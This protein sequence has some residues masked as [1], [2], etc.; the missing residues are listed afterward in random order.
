MKK[1]FL[2]L[3]LLTTMFHQLLAS[4]N[5]SGVN[6]SNAIPHSIG[7]NNTYSYLIGQSQLYIEFNASG[8]EAF[9]Q[10]VDNN[11]YNQPIDILQEITVYRKFNCSSLTLVAQVIQSSNAVANHLSITNLTVGAD[12]LIELKRDPQSSLPIKSF[13]MISKAI[14]V[15]NCPLAGALPCNESVQN[16]NFEFADTISPIINFAFEQGQICNWRAESGTPDYT[17]YNIPIFPDVELAGMWNSRTAIDYSS[18]SLSNLLETPTANN[19]IVQVSLRVT[20]GFN[21]TYVNLGPPDELT[22]YLTNTVD[23][24]NIPGPVQLK[25]DN[26]YSIIP[27]SLE[28]GTINVSQT[29]FQTYST[30]TFFEQVDDIYDRIFLVSDN[31]GPDTTYIEFDDVSLRYLEADAGPDQIFDQICGD[32]TTTIGPVDCFVDGATYNWSP[33]IGLSD[34]T[35]RNPI[36]N[37]A[38]INGT[39]TYTLTVTYPGNFTST[40]EVDV[41][42]QNSQNVISIPDGEDITY[43][44]TNYAYNNFTFSNSHTTS[45]TNSHIVNRT[46][47]IQGEFIIDDEFAFVDCEFYMGENAKIIVDNVRA[48]FV[49]DYDAVPHVDEFIKTCD[50]NKFWDG[51]YVQGNASGDLEIGQEMT[52]SNSKNGVVVEDGAATSLG[53]ITFN[54][55]HRCLQ[56]KAT[57]S[58]NEVRILESSFRC[59][60]PLK[61]ET[62]NDYYPQYCIEVN[63][64]HSTTDNIILK[65]AVDQ[66]AKIE[67]TAGGIYCK[68]SST[69][70][71][72]NFV[73]SH[74]QNQYTLIFPAPPVVIP[75]STTAIT[76]VTDAN[77]S[78]DYRV[79]DNT[80]SSCQKGIVSSGDQLLEVKDESFHSSSITGATFLN[81]SDNDG[82]IKVLDN[83]IEG[84]QNGIYLSNVSDVEIDGNTID[85]EVQGSSTSYNS[86]NNNQSLGIY[87]NNFYHAT[88]SPV[89][90]NWEPSIDIR[91]NTIKHASTGISCYF[92]K[93]DIIN[94]TILDMNDNL[95]QP[96]CLPGNPCPATPAYGIKATGTRHGY[97]IRENK[98]ENDLS[99][100]STDPVNLDVIGITMEYTSFDPLS[101][102]TGQEI[103]CNRTVNVG[104]GLRFVGD[105]MSS[106][107]IN[108]NV[109]E[110][111]YWGFVLANNGFIGDVGESGQFSA[112]NRW[113]GSYSNP[114][115]HTF[116]DE[117]NGSST[118]FYVDN[119]TT[120]FPL[121]NI[122]DA[123]PGF[124]SMASNV[125][126]WPG[127]PHIAPLNCSIRRKKSGVAKQSAYK[128]KGGKNVVWR[129]SLL[130]GKLS[131]LVHAA[132]SAQRL[133]Q[134]IL[135]WQLSK[136]SLLRND[137]AWKS[138]ADSMKNTPLGKQLSKQAPRANRK[139]MDNFDA[140]L[141]Q[142]SHLINKYEQKKKFS[143]K[144]TTDLKEIASLCPYYDGIA[145]YQAR[146]LMQD[147][148]LGFIVNNCEISQVIDTSVIKRIKKIT[149]SE[150]LLFPNPTK[151]L[152]NINFKVE[153][154]EKVNFE[155][156]DLL[157]KE[158]FTEPLKQGTSHQLKL[159]VMHTGIYFY[160]LTDINGSIRSGK[161]V[162][163]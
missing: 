88:P 22:V 119:T 15:L 85:M 25:L 23:L 62:G 39:R 31:N 7:Q 4:G 100:Y 69:V 158:V 129:K 74:F 58:G 144:D 35:A 30:F 134:Q 75:V 73:F 121:I 157:G 130:K 96:S 83:T 78:V 91:D 162:I 55:N 49:T 105:N 80:Y 70:V 148:G 127:N 28:I 136:D 143:K 95:Y 2:S 94:N 93:A 26:I 102:F 16:G 71:I 72:E 1:L 101:S 76:L 128:G 90:S 21:Q 81:I 10:I 111:N 46:F 47:F 52:F 149:H 159:S 5:N 163:E 150:F 122:T 18:E 113:L 13:N 138:Y 82:L 6:C 79:R 135:Y 84:A 108:N 146:M 139:G 152:L 137:T 154:D 125:T 40:D 118:T 114:R 51:I 145:V 48:E 27:N 124:L 107:K 147:L 57:I 34:P 87:V 59:D 53:L 86:K 29:G 97:N 133:N 156:Y 92:T 103:K 66:S 65:G 44:K 36:V 20:R 141:Y 153:E 41:T 37:P 161:L 63:D 116:A 109:M 64:W 98:V 160:R 17:F 68:N 12:Y 56:V 117:S 89:P 19:D 132:D 120:Y 3:V 43:L 11:N 24:D 54:R 151:S 67:S 77:T 33:P 131:Y 142:M 9:I 123:T 104:Q 140:N 112:A 126:P 106:N 8:V 14:T 32:N 60:S 38:S 61:D 115:S 42:N 110:D 155:I 50:P 99:Q 45:S